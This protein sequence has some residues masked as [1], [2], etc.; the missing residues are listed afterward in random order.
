MCAAG[1]L[2]SVSVL[3]ECEASVASASRRSAAGGASSRLG[4]SSWR[5]SS[6]SPARRAARER[7]ESR[8][9][10]PASL[11]ALS[12]ATLTAA[13]GAER[14]RLTPLIQP[15]VALQPSATYESL[16]PNCNFLPVRRPT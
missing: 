8:T 7:R 10:P 3:D 14:E 2:E 11:S 6:L 16:D 15:L 9:P 1:G 13:G 4:G 12:D 5:G